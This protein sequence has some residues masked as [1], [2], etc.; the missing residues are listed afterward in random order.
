MKRVR[1]L[2]TGGYLPGE[3]ITNA[4]IEGL[5]GSLPD[6]V[7]EGIQVTHRHWMIDPITGEHQET[8]SDM[9]YKAA[10]QALDLAGVEPAEVELLVLSTA[11]P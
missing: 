5:G 3:P 11:S 7:L 2:S 10:K 1:V 6:D 9:A 8:N 4:A